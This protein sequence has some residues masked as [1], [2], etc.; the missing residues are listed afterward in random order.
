MVGTGLAYSQ[1]MRARTAL[2][3]VA[4]VALG[5]FAAL[6][7]AVFTAPTDLNLLFAR[8]QAPL[9]VILLVV[10]VAL[11]LLYA[12]LLAWLETAAP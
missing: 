12:A 10:I 9:G 6:N 7:W 3:L 2:L 8:A 1:G 11:T 4:L 5:L